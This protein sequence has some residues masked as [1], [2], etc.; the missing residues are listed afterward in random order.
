MYETI[1]LKQVVYKK[2]ATI[3]RFLLKKNAVLS[4]FSENANTGAPSSVPKTEKAPEISEAFSVWL[5]I[6]PL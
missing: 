5:G 3:L 4:R 1:R 6:K 2:S